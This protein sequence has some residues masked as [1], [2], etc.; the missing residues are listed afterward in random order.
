MAMKL[1]LVL[2]T[3][4]RD[5]GLT[6]YEENVENPQRKYLATLPDAP[7]LRSYLLVA[8]VLEGSETETNYAL[9]RAPKI[10]KNVPESRKVIEE[11]LL[12]LTLQRIKTLHPTWK[13]I[14]VE[15]KPAKAA[16]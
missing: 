15:E 6:Y 4:R 3:T 12:G 8:G 11:K 9:E 16:E 7:A 13:L 14:N 10:M 1:S 5:G 2:L